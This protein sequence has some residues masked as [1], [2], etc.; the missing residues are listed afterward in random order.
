MDEL[1]RL[2]QNALQS[3]PEDLTAY[4]VVQCTKNETATWLAAKFTK[5][6]KEAQEDES[7]D[8]LTVIARNI[9]GE[10]EEESLA[11]VSFTAVENNVN[12]QIK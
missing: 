7:S 1:K 11:D 12:I 5:Y 8:F 9:K 4:I 2:I 3:P 6:W 10:T